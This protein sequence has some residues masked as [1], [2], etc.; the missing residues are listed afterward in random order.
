MRLAR[1]AACGM[2]AKMKFP[3]WLA[4]LLL[5][6]VVCLPQSIVVPG[7]ANPWLAGMPNG[8][9]A[10]KCVDSVADFAPMQ[11]PAEVTVLNVYPGQLLTF[12]AS[13]AV[14]HDAS[15]AVPLN[16]PDGNGSLILGHDNGAENGMAN[17][18]API[19]S[20]IGVFLGSGVPSLSPAP[21]SLNFS[22]PAS[23]DYS[24]LTPQVKQPFFVGNGRTSAQKLQTV[25]VPP[26]ATR[27]FLGV[28]DGCGW[29]SNRGSFTA[30]IFDLAPKLSI[31]LSEAGAPPQVEVCWKSIQ[32]VKYQVQINSD[33]SLPQWTNLASP[34]SGTGST[35]CIAESVVIEKPYRLYRVIAFGW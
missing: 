35:L 34:L 32:S 11:S 4:T 17:I 31:Q 33:D 9:T 26:G 25:V 2:L 3:V 22:T 27:L 10:S 8:S 15:S 23:R 5:S 18:T 24:R 20:L 1:E 13:G 6:M 16:P 30:S 19:D 12:T 29:S 21:A 7:T 14:S 28:M